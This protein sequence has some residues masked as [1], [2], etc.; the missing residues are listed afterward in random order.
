VSWERLSLKW[1]LF[2][3]PIAIAVLI[4]LMAIDGDYT[5]LTRQEFFDR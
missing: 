2:I 4:T 1:V 3:P 5:F